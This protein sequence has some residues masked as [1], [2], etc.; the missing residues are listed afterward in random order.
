ML[1]ALDDVHWLDTSSRAVLEF[2]FRR[3]RH[4]NVAVLVSARA[5]AE[6]RALASGPAFEGERLTHVQLGGLDV[7]AVQA[8]LRERLGL[9]LTRPT[10]LQVVDASG[11]NPFFAL[12]LGRA[13]DRRAV[14]VSPPRPRPR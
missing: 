10:L 3:L 9:A 1:V 12:E 6:E 2:A 14:P 7:N 8:L 5:D 4:E 13:L 11:G